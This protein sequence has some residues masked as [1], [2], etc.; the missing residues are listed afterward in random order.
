MTKAQGNRE[1]HN[2]P[3]V[4]FDLMTFSNAE[5]KEAIS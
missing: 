4:N 3:S 1:T 5:D 2:V